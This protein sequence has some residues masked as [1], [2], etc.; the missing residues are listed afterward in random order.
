MLSA[1]IPSTIFCVMV[2]SASETMLCGIP[3]PKHG[4]L[5]YLLAKYPIRTPITIPITHTNK[6]ARSNFRCLWSI[7]SFVSKYWPLE[8]VP[9]VFRW[10]KIT[11]ILT[12]PR[13]KVNLDLS[14]V[15]LTLLA[16][17]QG[18]RPSAFCAKPVVINV[19]EGNVFTFTSSFSNF[20]IQYSH[21]KSDYR[22]L[23]R[24]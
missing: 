16:W 2:S 1:L 20:L 15:Y 12:A 6:H 23:I 14:T 7:L 22:L 17:V 5:L 18:S 4:P 3:D 21:Y 11:V 24:K 10:N 19:S 13:S 9:C 8:T